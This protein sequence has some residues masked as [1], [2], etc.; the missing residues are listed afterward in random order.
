MKVSFGPIHEAFS[1]TDILGIMHKSRPIF[2]TQ[3]HPEARGG[4]LD[5]AY[6]FDTYLDFV[7]KFKKDQTVFQPTRDNRPSPLLIDILGKERVGVAPT[8]GTANKASISKAAAANAAWTG[9]SSILLDKSD[10]QLWP[11][12]DSD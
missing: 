12:L 9:L 5:S 10:G 6:L 1:E 11:H 4:P 3:F 2:G 8:L 7:Q